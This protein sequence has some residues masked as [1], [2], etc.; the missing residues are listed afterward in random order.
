MAKNLTRSMR[1]VRR[2]EAKESTTR[3]ATPIM[4]PRL[5]PDDL[6]ERYEERKMRDAAHAVYRESKSEA[7][8]IEMGREMRGYAGGGMVKGY[9]AGGMVR[10]CKAGQMTGKKFSGSY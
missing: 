9:E 6:A 5:R 10:G 1:P 8:D 2:P 4:R 3:A 7:E